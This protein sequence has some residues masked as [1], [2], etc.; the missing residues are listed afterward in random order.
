MA[1]TSSRV[2]RCLKSQMF[3][4]KNGLRLLAVAAFACRVEAVAMA[5]FIFWIW[6]AN[7]RVTGPDLACVDMNNV[8]TQ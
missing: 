8:H 6:A 2:L 5:Y 4:K 7:M 3:C 1:H